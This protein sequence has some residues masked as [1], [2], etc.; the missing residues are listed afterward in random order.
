MEALEGKPATET[1]YPESQE[2]VTCPASGTERSH[3]IR[4]DF[5]IFYDAYEALDGLA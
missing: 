3:R 5:L 4:F 1:G 2:G